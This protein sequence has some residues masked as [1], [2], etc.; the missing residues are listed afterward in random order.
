MNTD[1]LKEGEDFAKFLRQMSPE[2]RDRVSE[3]NIRQSEAEYQSFVEAFRKGNCYICMRPVVSFS[4]KLPCVHWLL[5]PKGFKKHDFPAVASRFGFFQIQSY[6]RWVANQQGFAKHI[7]DLPEEGTGTKLFEVTI[8]YRNLEWSLSCAESDY[9]GHQTSQHAKYPHYHFQMRIDRRP[10]INFSDYHV[11][12]KKFDVLNIEAK[13]RLP[14]EVRHRFLH[15]E[16]MGDVLNDETVEELV[17]RSGRT[18]ATDDASLHIETL[19][20]ADKGTTIRGEDLYELIQEAK[21]KGVTLAS[22]M[23]QVPNVSTRVLVAPGP[24]VVEQAP[25]AGRKKR[26]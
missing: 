13:R 9:V 26:P 12:F 25:R 21:A 7:N 19:A 17:K 16:G 14:D 18:D 15:G 4:R 8:R 10:F 24:G 1:L 22:L 2:E 5:K 6:L 11:P 23:H 3:L 20:M